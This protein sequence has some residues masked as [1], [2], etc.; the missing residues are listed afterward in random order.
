MSSTVAGGMPALDGS[1][2]GKSRRRWREQA[3]HPDL[4]GAVVGAFELEN[5]APPGGGP[6]KTLA[7]H[8][9]LGAGCAESQPVAGGAYPADLLR[10]REGVLVHVREVR[11]E[12][13]L[14]RDRLGHLGPRVAHQHR[15][16]AHG[17]IKKFGTRRIHDLASLAPTDDRA[18]FGGEIEFPVGAGGKHLHRSL[19]RPRACSVRSR[20]IP[21]VPL[22][23]FY[24]DSPAPALTTR[25][26]D[27]CVATAPFS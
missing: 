9:C 18:E 17:K 16:P 21:L 26:D 23:R 24:G 4:V 22:H 14:T 15:A 5:H 11:T 27:G 10:Q 2:R 12:S 20:E 8:V 13:R 19:V 1:G 6:R 25:V 7:V 3:R